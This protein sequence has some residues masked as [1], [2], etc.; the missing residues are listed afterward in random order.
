MDNKKAKTEILFASVV[1]MVMTV[2]N[3]SGLPATLFVNIC[4]LDI[5]P[6][7]FSLMVNFVL[8]A[9]VF[10]LGWKLLYPRWCFGLNVKGLKY[11][12]KKYGF[13]GILIFILSTF[14]FYIGVRPF[15]NEPTITKVLVEG[16]IYYIGVAIIEEL[17]IRGL[18]L[19]IIE[20][21]LVRKTNATQYAIVLS[22]VI[23]GVGHIFGVLGGS[24]LTI[25]AKVVWTV[26]LGLYLGAIY[27]KTNN[28]WAPIILH[29]I[30]DFC[31]WPFCYSAKQPYPEISLWILLLVYCGVGIYGVWIML[32]EKNYKL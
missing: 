3:I 2:M 16:F 6:F 19:N 22:S 28:L 23:F 25:V 18:L 1:T 21:L 9:I 30:I 14:A 29:M 10:L 17:Y 8:T 7:Y 24:A 13:S 4:V 5:Q 11:G 12:L 31:A 15:D 27:K 26:A 20:K 32:K